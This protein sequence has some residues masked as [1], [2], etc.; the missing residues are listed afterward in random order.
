MGE[1]VETSHRDRERI[2]PFSGCRTGQFGAKTGLFLLV[3]AEAL[4]QASSNQTTSWVVE[5][6][7]FDLKRRNVPSSP[8]FDA[9]PRPLCEHRGRIFLR[10]THK[11]S[12][13]SSDFGSLRWSKDFKKLAKQPG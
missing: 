13:V 5:T 3:P 11:T 4:Y 7:Y 6:S 10:L 2:S 8:T 1:P 12:T 9:E